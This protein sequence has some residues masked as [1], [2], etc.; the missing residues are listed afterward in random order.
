VATQRALDQIEHRALHADRRPAG[1][2]PADVT[3][4]DGTSPDD[5]LRCARRQR[6]TCAR[7]ER[8]ARPERPDQALTFYSA[9]CIGELLA[10]WRMN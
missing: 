10:T 4:P 6:V 9:G 2:A 5:G 1:D 3:S 7:G 8:I